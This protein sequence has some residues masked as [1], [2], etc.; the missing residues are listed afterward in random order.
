MV[1]LNVNCEVRG[2]WRVRARSGGEFAMGGKGVSLLVKKLQNALNTMQ[3]DI[4]S[5]DDTA[6]REVGAKQVARR[7]ASS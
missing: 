1:T 2:R 3:R 4:N 7:V 6:M 5:E